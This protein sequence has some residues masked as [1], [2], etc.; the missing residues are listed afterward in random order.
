M[1]YSA[2]VALFL[3]VATSGV[4]AWWNNGHLLVARIAYDILQTS[5]PATIQDVE[6]ILAVLKKSDPSWTSKEV[7]HPFVECV[8]FADDIK[9]KGASW[10]ADW[11]FVDTPFLDEGGKISDYN[12]TPD[13]HNATEA[14]KGLVSWFNLDSGYT[15]NYEYQQV[16]SHGTSGHT[17]N[18]SLSTA[19]RL[20][21]HYVGDVHQPLHATA[22]VDHEYPSG[23]RGGNSFP[24]PIL[25]GAKNLHAVWDSVVYAF[26]NDIA[27]PFT[28]SGWTQLGDIAKTLFNKFPI[29]ST[30]ANQLNPDV[31]AQQSF[32]VSQNFVYSHITEN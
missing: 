23:D 32:Q 27:L 6:T 20:L 22:R 24:V 14:I 12:F 1:K 7:N 9:A 3:G 17:I 15:N 30:D 13:A 28:A 10:Q 29:S 25:D 26:P 16:T 21:M 31:W 5:S 2:T 4:Q 8:T 18:D 11:H 19:L